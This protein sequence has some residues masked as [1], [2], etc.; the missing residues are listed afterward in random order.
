MVDVS[1]YG[2]RGSCPSPCEAN[3][4]YGGNTACV[5]VSVDGEP[6]IILDL[7][8]GLRAFGQTQPV[9]GTF[10]ASAFVT[11]LHWDHVQGLPFF[12]PIDRPGAELDIY[13]PTQADTSLSGAFGELMRPPYFPV[14]LEE[15]RGEIRF[16]DQI[17][18]DLAVG[19]AKVTVRRIPHV[20][21]T[22]GYRVA[23]GGSTVAYI[24]DHQAPVA[25]DSVAEA[26]L[27]L[28]D[29]ADVLIHDAQYTPDEFKEKSHWGHCTVDYAVSVARQAGVGTLVLFHHDPAHDDDVLDD[30]LAGAQ[31]TAGR[32]GPEILAASEGLVIH[33]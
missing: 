27:E 21:P 13:G 29:G 31:Q 23:C 19:N 11:H 16:H 24:S 2:V 4:R 25:L 8:T 32:G 33:L 30:L 12:P 28:A 5:V 1:F 6:P 17:D 10:R 14:R 7:G 22:V 15:L 26:A 18:G 9:D 3:R 20:G